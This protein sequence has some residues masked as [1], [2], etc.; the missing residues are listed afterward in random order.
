M[1]DKSEGPALAA[2]VAELR[3]PEAK[4]YVRARGTVLVH[5]DGY[6]PEDMADYRPD[7]P[8]AD[9]WELLMHCAHKFGF[10]RTMYAWAHAAVHAAE[11]G[12][13]NDADETHLC[14]AYVAMMEG[15]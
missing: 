10:T 1:T 7:R 2:R 3:F 11:Y 13:E 4:V 6:K 12:V 14:R 8:G 9:A 15:E 5:F